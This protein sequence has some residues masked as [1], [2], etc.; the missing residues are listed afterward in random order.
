MGMP[1]YRPCMANNPAGTKLGA[2]SNLQINLA[3]V[4]HHNYQVFQYQVFQPDE[5]RNGTSLE[6]F[7]LVE[8]ADCRQSRLEALAVPS[9]RGRYL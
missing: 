4:S 1:I 8:R 2:A 3:E 6:E 7:A 5:G 9:P